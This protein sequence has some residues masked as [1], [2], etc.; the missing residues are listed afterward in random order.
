MCLW[1][2]VV[3]VVCVVLSGYCW[4]SL[5]VAWRGLL[6][7]FR[8][9]SMD[10]VLL[11]RDVT[12]CCALVFDFQ[13]WLLGAFIRVVPLLVYCLLVDRRRHSNVLDV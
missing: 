8:G 4:M 5:V 6:S 2:F 13:W 1:Y 9:C 10:V 12:F 11:P 7:V 3:L